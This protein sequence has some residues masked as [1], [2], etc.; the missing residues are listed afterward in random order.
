VVGNPQRSRSSK[1]LAI[2]VI[3]IVIFG[4]IIPY[5]PLA[6]PLEFV[7]LPDF[8]ISSLQL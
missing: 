2:T 1:P 4:L 8:A 3:L 6:E 7:P 5:T